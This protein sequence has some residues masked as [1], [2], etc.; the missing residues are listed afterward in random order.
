M[1]EIAEYTAQIAAQATRVSGATSAPCWTLLDFRSVRCG[2]E[3]TLAWV[4]AAPVTLLLAAIALLAA[5]SNAVTGALEAARDAALDGQWWRVLTGHLTHWS[6][7]HLAWDLF[8]FVVLGFLLECRGRA[9]YLTLLGA[10]A[11]T[12]SVAVFWLQPDIVTYRGL[13][14]VDTA[15]FVAVCLEMLRDA[16]RNIKAADA[17]SRDR[18][19]SACAVL[20][21]AAL[22]AKTIYEYTTG[23]TL[24]VACAE[25]GFT[26]LALSHLAG[27]IAAVA[28]ALLPPRG[29]LL[30]NLTVRGKFRPR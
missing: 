12:V 5:S 30:R 14:G 20:L 26:P 2:V 15:L 17:S 18:A 13:S 19:I 8:M 22:V 27:A 6:A 21:L 7:D 1:I 16:R 3:R 28:T 23:E 10:S 29:G 24:F 25:A 11:V 4:R 9:R